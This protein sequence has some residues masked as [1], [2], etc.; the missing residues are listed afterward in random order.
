MTLRPAHAGTAGRRSMISQTL[1]HVFN[2]SQN[3]HLKLKV[4]DQRG[5]AMGSSH[6]V[7][8][9]MQINFNIIGKSSYDYSRLLRRRAEGATDN[10]TE[11]DQDTVTHNS[12]SS[13]PPCLTPLPNHTSQDDVDWDWE[14]H[15]NHFC[16]CPLR[17]LLQ[18]T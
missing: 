17:P 11:L 7:H 13:E 16:L 15:H 14:L 6:S 2:S 8:I 5:L 12:Y 1:P 10:Q 3:M 9:L 18:S 4:L